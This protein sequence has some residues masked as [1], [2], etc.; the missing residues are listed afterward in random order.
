MRMDALPDGETVPHS[1]NH[2]AV[3]P[4]CL[5]A[6]LSDPRWPMPPMHARMSCPFVMFLAALCNVRSYFADDFELLKFPG[7]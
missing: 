3:N 1:A 2:F 4:R 5:A 7:W 6:L